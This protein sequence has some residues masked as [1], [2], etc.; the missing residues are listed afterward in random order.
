MFGVWCSVWDIFNVFVCVVEGVMCF[1]CVCVCVCGLWCSVCD[2]Y[3]V[4]VCVLYCV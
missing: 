1:M 4:F 3:D 2:V